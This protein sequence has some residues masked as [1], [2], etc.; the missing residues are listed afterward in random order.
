MLNRKA[1]HIA[2]GAA[3][4]LVLATVGYFAYAG[5]QK[6]AQQRH[7]AQLVGD[8]SDKLREALTKRASREIVEAIDANAQAVKAPR[9]RLLADT[10]EQYIVAS[11]E[12]VRRRIDG[13]RLLR[14]AAAGRRALEGHMAHSS[15]RSDA[16][17]KEAL[18]LKRKVEA[19]HSDL[20]ATM[21]AF[22]DLLFDLPDTGK[23]LAPRIGAEPLLEAKVINEARKQGQSELAQ[24]VRELERMRRLTP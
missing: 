23:R 17:F 1:I 14:Q 18:A 16:W 20:Q 8:T 24:A 22:D 10:A 15:R 12:I 2:V 13:D 4:A 3:A 19:D 9:E 21:K 6:R 5:A 7:V 11:R